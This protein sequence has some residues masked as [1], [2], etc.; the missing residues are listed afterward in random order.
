MVP[1]LMPCFSANFS[2]SGR[3]AIE[4]SSFMISTIAAAGEVASQPGKV[5]SCLGV[6][7]SA[8]NAARLRHDRKDVTLAAQCL[9]RQLSR[10]TA[11]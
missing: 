1:I 3:L 4:P 7:R 8:Q 10:P 9:R 6:T 11:T 2:R 5:A